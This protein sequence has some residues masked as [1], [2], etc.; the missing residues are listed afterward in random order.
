MAIK[1]YLD[2]GSWVIFE[3]NEDKT[4]AFEKL[5]DKFE[6]GKIFVITT[7]NGQPKM[8]IDMKKV[9]HIDCDA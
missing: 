7:N 3:H 6:S 8:I 5:R 4:L 9:T 1:L 2:N